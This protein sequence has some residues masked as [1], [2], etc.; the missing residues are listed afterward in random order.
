M[1]RK[2]T[3]QTTQTTT[4]GNTTTASIKL[5]VLAVVDACRESTAASQLAGQALATATRATQEAL[6]AIL[7][8]VV[9]DPRKPDPAKVKSC[10]QALD[11][12]LASAGLPDSTA[13]R[14]TEIADSAPDEARAAARIAA[15]LSQRLSRA[16]KAAVKAACDDGRKTVRAGNMTPKRAEQVLTKRLAGVQLT[17]ADKAALHDAC[18]AGAGLQASPVA[19]QPQ[20]TPK[21]AE[22]LLASC[23]R[24]ADTLPPRE[25]LTEIMRMLENALAPTTNLPVTPT[26]AETKARTRTRRKLKAA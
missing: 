13:C 25:A 8:G 18:R 5:L 16:T 3:T 2:N 9:P 12:A 23:Q 21:V 22:N 7:D 6:D 17:D 1:A 4:A 15:A 19:V 14:R 11:K 24:I 10:W 26:P 20:V